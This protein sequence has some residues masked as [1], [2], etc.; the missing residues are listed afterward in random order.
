MSLSGDPIWLRQGL[1]LI[2]E[3]NISQ[4]IPLGSFLSKPCFGIFLERQTINSRNYIKTYVDSI[5][6]RYID[7]EEII[8]LIGK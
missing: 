5:G 4:G 1:F 8:D 6:E 7:E 3:I 2:K